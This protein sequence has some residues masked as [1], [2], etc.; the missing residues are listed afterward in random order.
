VQTELK[1]DIL[2]RSYIILKKKYSAFLRMTSSA[3]KREQGRGAP[4]LN[5]PAI[6]KKT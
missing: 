3:W 6:P 2:F 1:I 4:L 5:A